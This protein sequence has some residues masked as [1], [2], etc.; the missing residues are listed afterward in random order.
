[1]FKTQ[2]TAPAG[3]TP[4][5]PL[6]WH[7]FDVK[8]VAAKLGTDPSVGLNDAVARARRERYGQN[9]SFPVGRGVRTRVACRQLL[10]GRTLTMTAAILAALAAGAFS[11]AFCLVVVE[12]VSQGIFLGMDRLRSGSSLTGALCR[13]RRD[14]QFRS[15]DPVQLVPGDVV[16]IGPGEIIPADL[17]LMEACDLTVDETPLSGSAEPVGK[18]TVPVASG[19]DFPEMT[20]MGWMGTRVIQGKGAGL[21]VATGAHTEWARRCKKDGPLPNRTDIRGLVH[22]GSARQT[23]VFLV[24][25]GLIVWLAGWHWQ[26]SWIHRIWCLAALLA[27]A[28]AWQWPFRPPVAPHR[29]RDPKSESQ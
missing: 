5:R 1:M 3:K 4:V 29:S 2:T 18:Y 8:S 17:R 6:A 28:G 21:V 16:I 24:A 9:H 25:G 23:V 22:R 27:A 15:M 7:A 13:V 26:L 19:A 14:S 11:E 10:N 12:M 20:S